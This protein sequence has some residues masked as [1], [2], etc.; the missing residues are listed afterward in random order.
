M[1]EATGRFQVTGMGEETYDD[2]ERGK[3]TKANG[4]QEFSGSVE[5]RGSVEWLMCYL[6]DGT[7]EYV[8]L[9]TVDGSLDGRSGSFVL[10]ASGR[11][12]GQ[13]SHGQWTIV[14]GSGTGEL[15]GISGSG[16]FEAGPG[17][18]A[19]YTLSYDLD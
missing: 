13:R 14:S 3:L 19:T 1:R 12:D 11:F 17:P 6:E 10:T 5:G 4:A 9:Q 2:R 8:G 15:A 7:A 16:S 18:Q